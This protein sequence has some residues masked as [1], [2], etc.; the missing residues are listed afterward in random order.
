MSLKKYFELAKHI[1]NWTVYFKRQS[2]KGITARFVTTGTPLQF[3]VPPNF[4][5][6]FREMFMEDFY[7]IKQVMEGLPAN[8]TIIDIGG[9][10]GY[11]SFMMLSKLPNSKVIAYEPLLPNTKVFNANIALN[12]GLDKRVAVHQKAVT[13][14]PIDFIEI[15]FDGGNNNTVVASV[16]NDFDT[17]NQ[18]SEKIPATSLASIIADNDLQQIDLLKLDCEG[19]EYPILYE[20]PKSVFTKIKKMVIEVHELDK[21]TRN[22]KYLLNFL[23][24]QGY[25]VVETMAEN[26]CFSLIATQKK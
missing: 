13:G 26:N 9:N 20:S 17:Q 23:Q 24:Q 3:D 11:F 15:F 6:V 4:Y 5:H 1:K 2:E 22:N 25:D 12:E 21:D 8:A 7:D 10:V 14:T 16:Y 19:S 18:H